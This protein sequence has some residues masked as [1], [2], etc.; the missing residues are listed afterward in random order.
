ML[1]RL[2]KLSGSIIFFAFCWIFR[3]F[4]IVVGKN[5]HAIF[6]I[7]YYHTVK[8]HQKQAFAKQMDYLVRWTQP[9]GMESSFS[10]E[11]RK[12]Y[13]AVTFDDGYQ[14]VLGNALP[15]LLKR[16]IPSTIFI[17]TGL[18]GN[19]PS[20]VLDSNHPFSIEKIMTKDQLIHLNQESITVGSHS[21]SHPDLSKLNGD[22]IKTELLQSKSTL[23]ALLKKKVELMSFP[24]GKYNPLVIQIAKEIGYTRV[25]SI[26]PTLSTMN[27]EDFVYGRF[28]AEPTDWPIEFVLKI[29]GAYRWLYFAFKFKEHVKSMFHLRKTIFHISSEYKK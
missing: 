12:Y 8:S 19:S 20:W 24:H 21:V 7:L 29:H 22:Q 18:F 2:I 26:S 11:N 9:L 6:V 16:K 28:N 15:E 14:S 5:P 10:L 27:E 13:T 4:K 3:M 17:V 25:F 23:E 1:T